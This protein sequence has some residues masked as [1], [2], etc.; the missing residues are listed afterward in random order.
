EPFDPPTVRSVSVVR[1]GSLA[2]DSD[3]V[4]PADA[5]LEFLVPHVLE[6]ASWGA[7]DYLL[8]VLPSG[9]DALPRVALEDVGLDGTIAVGDVRDGGDFERV[10]DAVRELSSATSVIGAIGT[11]RGDAPGGQAGLADASNVSLTESASGFVPA[12]AKNPARPCVHRAVDADIDR[13]YLGTLSLEETTDGSR[14]RANGTSAGG[15]RA[16]A[17]GCLTSRSDGDEPGCDPTRAVAI[18]VTDLIGLVNRRHV[19]RGQTA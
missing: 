6:R 14:E 3:A 5:V 8:V 16:A 4:P 2:P 11:A 15:D 12:C 10:R 7:L 17:T 19:A 1:L 13:P 9:T 18:A